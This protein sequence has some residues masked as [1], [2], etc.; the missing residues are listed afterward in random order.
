MTDLPDLRR[1]ERRGQTLDER[2]AGRRGVKGP[3]GSP[4]AEG[5]LKA[6]AVAYAKGDWP[7][8]RRRLGW[9]GL[10]IA[11]AIDG[12]D[13]EE[14]EAEHVP[15]DHLKLPLGTRWGRFFEK[16]AT[17]APRVSDRLKRSE[18][19]PELRGLPRHERP[20]FGE[21]YVPFLHIAR[22]LLREEV[23]N[24]TRLLARPAWRAFEW[25]L[26][27]ELGEAG[28]LFHYGAF[29]FVR[30]SKKRGGE[31]APYRDY[32]T[33]VLDEGFPRGT[34]SPCAL[35]RL[36]STLS[37]DWVDSLAELLARLAGDRDELAKMFGA[38]GRVVAARPGLSD[39]HR[40][41][42]R[43]AC[44]TFESGVAVIYKPREVAL[45]AA[46]STFLGWMEAAGFPDPPSAIRILDRGTHGYCEVVVPGTLESK[47][48]VEAYFRRAG[49]LLA[50]S[51]L[52]G[53]RDLHMDNVIATAKGPVVIDAEACV[54]P[55]LAAGAWQGAGGAVAFA[56][57]RV[58]RSFA[59]TGL[60][61]MPGVDA[62]GAPFDVG[63]L[64]GTGGNLSSAKARVFAR[65]NTDEIM[66]SFQPT[67]AAA[68]PNLPS[69]AG[70][71][72]GAGRATA[73]D[74]PEALEAGF[75][76]A[77]R[78][79]VARKDQLA[80]QA[81][82]L[83][84]FACTE[85]GRPISTR[86]VFRPT[87]QYARLLTVLQRSNYLEH[88]VERSVA[89]DILNRPFARE[90][91]R[92][93]LW[94]L[95]IEERVALDRNDIPYFTIETRSRVLYS[96]SGEPIEE[97]V[98]KTGLEAL[99]ERVGRL[100]E[101]DLSEQRDILRTLLASSGPVPITA[102]DGTVPVKP[103]GARAE[104]QSDELIREAER[105]GEELLSEAIPTAD[106]GVTW[107]VPGARTADLPVDLYDGSAGVALFFAALAVATGREDFRKI[108][109]AVAMP[110]E[111]LPEPG[112]IGACRGLGSLLYGL[113]TIGN[114]LN[115]P[116]YW[117]LAG[118][119]A[120]A[121]TPERI[122]ADTRFDVEGGAA[123]AILGL[124]A[125]HGRTGDASLLEA[126]L[127]CGQHLL[128]NRVAPAEGQVAWPSEVGKGLAAR[129]E[130]AQHAETGSRSGG[131]CLAGFAHGA[132]GIALA[133]GR[134]AAASGR[135][136]FEGGAIGALE[137]E[138]AIFDHDAGNWPVL[139]PASG[140]GFASAARR[141]FMNA[142]C[143]GAPGIALARVGLIPVFGLNTLRGELEKAAAA[144]AGT[145]LLPLDHLCCGNMGI[146]EAELEIGQALGAR[147]HL[148]SARERAA[149]VLGRAGALHAYRLRST[150]AG[151][152]GQGP[153][154]FRGLAG[155][156]YTLLRL[157]HPERLPSVLAFESVSREARR[158]ASS[159]TTVILP[160][161]GIGKGTE[162]AIAEPGSQVEI[163][164]LTA[165]DA[166]AF[167]AMTFPAYRHLMA[168]R[169]APRHLE[170]TGQV[171]VAPVAIG[172]LV[173]GEPS[174]LVL[175]EIAD[176]ATALEVLSLFVLPKF[177]GRGLATSLLTALEGEASLAGL[178]RVQ[179]VY[180]TGQKTQDAFERVLA[181]ASWEKPETRM[182]TVRCTLAEARRTEWYSKHPLG[183]GMT[184]FPWSE[185]TSRERDGLMRSQR[186][187]G[188]IKPD[189]V[190]WNFDRDGFEPVSSLGVRLNG[191]IVG[192]V[193]NHAMS[194]KVVRFTCSFIR[195]DLGRRGRIVP[196][197][198]ESIRR[199]S[200]TAFEECTLTV[201]LHHKGM[202]S[203]IRRWCAPV[204]SFLGETRGTGKNL[205][206]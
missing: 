163:R 94:P 50:T 118:R 116:W 43:V 74:Y 95:T 11:D 87:D 55:V 135:L 38:S 15:E 140:S 19:L 23:G 148:A 172:A 44:L 29:D 61:S 128:A 164:R 9:D 123:G 120:S 86:L 27:A 71:D 185:L 84:G 191:E 26:L 65:A 196:V 152:E 102:N 144:I 199:L 51:W 193:L 45:E 25:Q 168:L 177:R 75:V 110:I 24:Q 165:S 200:E 189:L 112:G 158:S 69:L 58:K 64:T 52:L 1:I 12:L 198:S 192:W 28:E 134:L 96:Q 90:R 154:F 42:R 125:L 194:D 139:L 205:S 130:D 129:E 59:A 156:G 47:A 63:G 136:E 203:F 99:Q 115:D 137:Y 157:A 89:I 46:F 6:W 62:E 138:A 88:G 170:V 36:L 4:L 3:D 175:G 181:K 151:S 167:A 91:E 103:A 182:L 142:W 187:T 5:L 70:A 30:G 113:T 204:V 79:L 53:A 179:G 68:K 2:L 176:G 85:S 16:V 57:E 49:A 119:V 39:R 111:E 67:R 32:V 81:G 21:V 35:E 132:A 201:P 155:V 126:A 109:K 173:N 14:D 183:K 40:G 82:P 195:R 78:F 206:R 33:L 143:H 121:A 131:V 106:G 80:A 93:A 190:P 108:A 197:Y 188:W 114:M 146:V 7:A 92:P 34:E 37:L 124:L 83:S 161:L 104:I 147:S 169:R 171:P 17:W 160:C 127:L 66:M 186:E 149:A 98:E 22:A 166:Q 141:I 20:R 10:T 76:E 56:S 105:I 180:M 153:G 107:R 31:R 133:L 184:V 162:A 41:G 145:G 159:A 73:R 72:L 100:S 8:F 48:E 174:G 77:Y 101:E 60:L 122:A 13:D 150:Q 178:A 54:Q 18:D 202:E 117:E 97:V